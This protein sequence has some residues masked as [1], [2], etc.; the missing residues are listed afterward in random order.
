[1]RQL[2]AD[3]TSLP[4]CVQDSTTD[5][6]P[7]PLSSC[8]VT[9]HY[10]LPVGEPPFAV[11]ALMHTAD[12]PRGFTSL[13][14]E[15]G[16]RL[17]ESAEPMLRSAL[18]LHDLEAKLDQVGRDARLDPLTKLPNRRAWE[19]MVEKHEGCCAGIV[20]ADV[21][22]L[23]TVNDQRGHHVG[24]EYLQAV[25]Q[26]MAAS[27]REGD[28]LAR[29]GG[30]EFAIL[31]PDGDENVCRAAARRVNGALRA[32]PGFAGYPL[33]ASLGYAATPPEP[34]IEDAWRKA[35][36]E[37]YQGKARM[38]DRRPAVA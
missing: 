11:L 26:T 14:R 34:T 17:A 3:A 8:G 32:H 25:S 28:F 10:V 37:M 9:S 5:P 6:P 22:K 23:K 7:V 2:V 20:V 29:V 27:L 19:E 36:A 38:L 18:K 4:A 31:L 35:D 30:D 15:V 12:R 13:C 33:A 21:D 16:L 24:D 1:M